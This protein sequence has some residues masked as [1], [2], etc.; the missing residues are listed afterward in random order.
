MD[1]F[2]SSNLK[3]TLQRIDTVISEKRS[4]I[5]TGK[6]LEA[7]MATQNFID[8]ILEGFIETEAKKLFDVMVDPTGASP[9]SNEEIQ[10]ML[11]GIS[12]FKRYLANV[13]LEAE[14]A[15]LDIQ[16]EED[17]RTQVTSE[18]AM[19]EDI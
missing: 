15:P 17:Y 10:L 5:E 19:S 12:T 18:A 9:Y 3:E 14:N 4:A 8:V 11:A 6:K 1:E 13:K 16:I 2:A 7:L